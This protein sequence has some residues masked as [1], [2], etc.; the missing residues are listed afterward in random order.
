MELTEEEEKWIKSLQR[1]CN[2]C[3][4]SLWLFSDGTMTVL[5]YPEDGSPVMGANGGPNQDYVVG[6][7]TGIHSDVGAW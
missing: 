3:P 2:K 5:K 1:V 6:I 4:K 7:I